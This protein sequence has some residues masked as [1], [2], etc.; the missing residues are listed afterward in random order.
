M[1][2]LR[3]LPALRRVAQLFFSP[4]RGAVRRVRFFHPVTQTDFHVGIHGSWKAV[5]TYSLTGVRGK[6]LPR[7]HPTPERSRRMWNL[8]RAF[9]LI[10]TSC[11]LILMLVPA[12]GQRRGGG[13]P[14]ETASGRTAVNQP[15]LILRDVPVDV[16]VKG[17]YLFYLHGLIVENEGVRPTSPRFG[18]YEYEEI[19]ETFRRRGFI[20][21]S[22]PRPRG[23]DPEQY[24]AK[25]VG[26]IERLLAA[27]VPPRHVTVV[28]A[29]RGGG[30][31][32]IAST[33]LRNRQVKFAIMAACG[34]WDVYKRVGIDLSGAVLSVYDVED[35]V[36]GSC[37][38]FFKNS[39]GISKKKEVA[40]RLG[41]GHGIL[42]RPLRE[43]VDPV[44]DWAL[45]TK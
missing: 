31:A 9:R 40:L 36:A 2:S 24:A 42:Y 30:I 13:E 17:R 12:Y 41:L 35:D 26:Q 15:G 18:V 37:S 20:V 23:T 22:E 19:L 16:D 3:M 5:S 10:R 21:I 6:L 34:D 27:G 38:E 14:A 45:N 8:I 32:M 4:A 33:R 39:T 11:L 28:G 1:L 29:S 25:V 43:W 44:T 7:M